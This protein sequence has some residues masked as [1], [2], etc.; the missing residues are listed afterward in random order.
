MYNIMMDLL[1]YIKVHVRFEGLQPPITT[2]YVGTMLRGA[3]GYSLKRLFCIFKKRGCNS[4][5]LK[6]FCFYYKIFETPAPED[7]GFS[8]DYLPHP[9]LLS[10]LPWR[11]ENSPSIDFDF[12][13]LGDFTRYFPY[14]LRAFIQMGEWGLGGKRSHPRRILVMEKGKVLFSSTE[15]DFKN[16]EIRTMRLEDCPS[17]KEITLEILTPLKIK[18]RGRVVFPPNFPILMRSIFRRLSLLSHFFE[19][20]DLDVDF[21]ELLR[22][23]EG[24]NLV[25][26]E[27]RRVGVK[28]FSTRK[29]QK[30]TLLGFTGRLKFKGDLS[31][32]LPWLKAGEEFHAGKNTSFGFGKFRMI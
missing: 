18:E 21:K 14:F 28:R 23:A 2:P 30:I 10:P 13:L 22:R 17:R 16:P 5:P 29:K 8:A 24:V 26:W 32:F 3:L 11:Y 25:E 12:L 31:P 1:K 6:E 27:G 9:F 4:C 7:S 20:K 15:E 19:G